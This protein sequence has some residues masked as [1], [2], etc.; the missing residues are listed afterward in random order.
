[1][2]D[3]IN[4][5]MPAG[6]AGV[7][8]RRSLL[9]SLPGLALARRVLGQGQAAPLSI[10]GLHQVTLAVS[11][12]ERSLDFYQ[13]L[14]GMPVQARQEGKILLRIGD[15]PH[16]LA[17]TEAGPAGPHIDHFGLAVDNFDVERVVR[18]LAGHDVTPGGG[19]QGL[20]GGARRVRA[21]TRGDTPEL[22]M[23]DPNGLVIQLQDPR[24]CGG[25]G[26]L[27]DVC[28]APEPAP[29]TGSLALSGLSHLTINVPDP[30][31]TNAF[32]QRTFGMDIQ[33]YQAASPLMGVGPG[34]HF[35]MF[36]GAGGGGTARINH[37]CLSLA[38]FDV[39]RI[40]SALEDHGITP[41]GTEPG[42]SGPLLHRVTMR[43]PNRGGAPQGTP[44]LYF[45]DPD[46]LSIQLQDVAYCGGGG[47]LGGVCP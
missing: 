27:G 17:L 40:Q 26:P 14:F 33:A 28:A 32:Y 16:F 42:R 4:D 46:G 18:A 12:L 15:G 9:L 11:D 21:T 30:E 3:Q 43:M 41:R 29:A 5:P 38:N 20:S 37:A 22:H 24:Y 23:G 8:T 6:T 13:G 10:R 1:M 36:I 35:L 34:V 19:S 7:M 39:E 2:S 25:G 45:S 44:E 47:Y 31:L